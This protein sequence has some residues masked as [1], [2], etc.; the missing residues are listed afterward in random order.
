MKSIVTQQA[1]QVT[2][3]DEVNAEHHAGMRDVISGL[4]HFRRAGQGL[5]EA[6]QGCEHGEWS[7]WLAANIKFSAQTA[8][9][10]MRI[11]ERWPEIEAEQ[12]RKMLSF[13]ACLKLLA[14]PKPEPEPDPLPL[15][16]GFLPGNFGEQVIR[17]IT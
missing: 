11:A 5:V 6:K 4:E 12:K 9:G 16:F 15:P 13:S 17:M 7:A 8:R 1:G 2:L 3:A 10:Y 14:P